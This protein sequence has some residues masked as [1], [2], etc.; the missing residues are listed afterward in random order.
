ML[1][2]YC[3]IRDIL[4]DDKLA[5]HS[6]SVKIKNNVQLSTLIFG[7]CQRRPTSRNPHTPTE[8]AAAI[9]HSKYPGS[10]R[11]TN[12]KIIKLMPIKFTLLKFMQ[13]GGP[14]FSHFAQ[15]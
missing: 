6:L 1:L 7:E 13:N 4:E 14:L 5:L 15:G 3:T 9:I 12:I 11:K 10:V 2:I 8:K